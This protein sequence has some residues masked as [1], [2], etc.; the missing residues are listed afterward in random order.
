[1]AIIH[2]N[3]KDKNMTFKISPYSQ[4]LLLSLLILSGSLFISCQDKETT[5]SARREMPVR[6]YPVIALETMNIKHQNKYPATIEGVENIGIRAKVDGYIQSIYVDEGEFVRKG[7]PLFQLE[8]QALSQSAD[9]AQSNILVAESG[10]N[11]AQV[12]VDRL[13]PLVEKGI[14]SDVQLQ[15]AQ[16]NL[17][18]AKSRVAQAKSQFK[19][20]EENIGY[21]RIKSPVDGVVGRI[22]FRQGTLVG[23]SESMPLTYVSNIK[24]VYVYF[25]LNEKDF[26][27]F[28]TELEGK[29]LQ[30]KIDSMPPVEFIMANGKT[31]EHKGKIQTVSGQIDPR[32]GTINFRA[33]FPNPEY[34][35][36]DG[37]SGTIAIPTIYDNALVVPLQSTYEMQGRKFVY[38]V[39]GQDSLMSQ[40]LAY[41]AV[42][43][44]K[45]LVSDGIKK[46]DIILAAG[47]GNVQNGSKIKPKREE[48][49]NY[50]DNIKP[51]F[52]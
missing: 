9:A 27:N 10:V 1:M 17:A 16:A 18:S 31:Y 52:K 44:N 20:V 3:T 25:A 37:G 26:L 4:G 13:K 7:A 8:T 38:K 22:P 35:L 40:P 42:V 14:I 21:S 43:D 46:G 23:R 5:G 28:T 24:D 34:I 12:E 33:I 2:L 19:S 15:T 32:T 41:Y 39:V 29:S 11:A 49:S 50:I 48:F 6:E 47:V 30:E 51:V 45:V 36:R